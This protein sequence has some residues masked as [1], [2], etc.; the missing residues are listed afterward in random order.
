MLTSRFLLQGEKA[1][2]QGSGWEALALAP[3][4]GVGLGIHAKK[5][6]PSLATGVAKEFVQVFG[7]MLWKCPNFLTTVFPK[8]PFRNKF[9]M[10]PHWRGEQNSAI[11]FLIYKVFTNP[12]AFN[13]SW[14]SHFLGGQGIVL[15]MS[16]EL[17]QSTHL[18][19]SNWGIPPPPSASLSINCV[20]FS[21]HLPE[22][23]WPHLFLGKSL[24]ILSQLWIY[25][26]LFL[27]ERTEVGLPSQILHIILNLTSFV[28]N[29]RGTS[30]AVLWV[31]LCASD[32]WGICS[33]SGWRTKI[34]YAMKPKRKKKKRKFLELNRNKNTMH[35]L[36]ILAMMENILK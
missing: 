7:K 1:G 21:S 11:D 27:H 18:H 6:W 36:K 20:P 10:S 29:I 34:L 19:F 26:F 9:Y 31:R 28:K 3:P 17:L 5:P 33:I 32:A 2:C 12:S 35:Q 24:P 25:S 22:I 15:I 16:L 14:H 8:M 30:L 13:F 23:C 4:W